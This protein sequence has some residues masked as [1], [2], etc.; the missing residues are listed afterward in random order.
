[1]FPSQTGCSDF[2]GEESI[3]RSRENASH[4][5]PVPLPSSASGPVPGTHH[6]V[7]NLMEVDFTY[8]FHNVFTF[9]CDKSKPWRK[10]KTSWSGQSST[11]LDPITYTLLLV[12]ERATGLMD[13]AIQPLK[14]AIPHLPSPANPAFVWK[15]TRPSHMDSSF[16]LFLYLPPSL[17]PTTFKT[18]LCF[19]LLFNLTICKTNHMADNAG[20]DPSRRSHKESWRNEQLLPRTSPSMLNA[21]GQ[22]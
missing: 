3:P 11:Q 4:T 19:V 20:E 16:L 22:Q 6:F 9:K 15:K 2:W 21:P 14:T 5:A 13:G 8:F 10:G 17:N 12:G 7:V 1:M 18:K